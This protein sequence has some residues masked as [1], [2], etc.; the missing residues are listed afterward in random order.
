MKSNT[1]NYLVVGVFMLAMLVG[2]LG[3]VLAL[4]GHT[5][6][7]ADTYYTSFHDVTDIKFG[8]R[9]LYMGYPVGQVEAVEPVTDDSG[10]ISAF[11]LTLSVR[12]RA[13]QS[14]L[15]GLWGE[16]TGRGAPAAAWHIPVDSQAEIRTSGLLS[17]V[18][19]DIRAGE[20]GEFLSS[21]AQ[22][23]GR[24]REDV[25]QAMTDTANTIKD[26]AEHDVKEMVRNLTVQVNSF[27]ALLE[28][29]GGPLV[30]DLR[31]VAAQLATH[32][33]EIIEQFGTLSREL[34]VA[35]RRLQVVLDE[36]NAEHIR[37]VLGS[38]DLLA[39]SVV[40][41]DRETD[42]KGTLKSIGAASANVAELS[43]RANQRLDDVLGERTVR[44]FQSA[45]DDVASAARNIADLTRDLR[46]TREK[47]EHFI[48]TLDRITVENRPDL[49][50]S[51]KDLRL[52]MQ[53]VARHI[54]AITYNLE[55]TSRNMHEFSRQI[56]QNPGLL[57][58]GTP[59]KEA[60]SRLP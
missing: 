22:I 17:A 49:D 40:A 31:S 6:G 41:I 13:E 18:S 12:R 19:I 56:R 48:D 46:D 52:T 11:R 15:A 35:A 21:G 5:G 51:I 60:G 57:L 1:L 53:S 37:S 24:Q 2:L 59:P 30:R 20:S 29:E 14:W 45:L 10:R 16:A 43:D 58:G 38:T 54:G 23:E 25:L 47:L 34:T 8:T 36:E 44:K 39:Q 28:R 55:G 3:A 27:S 33:P 42:I 26:L 32:G 7:A 50:Q 4:Q 9:V